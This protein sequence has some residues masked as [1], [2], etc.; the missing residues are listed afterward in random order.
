MKIDSILRMGLVGQ[1]ERD[2][3]CGSCNRDPCNTTEMLATASLEREC[4][5]TEMFATASLE[6]SS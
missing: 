3:S 4:M 6:K 1:S 5:S 2:A